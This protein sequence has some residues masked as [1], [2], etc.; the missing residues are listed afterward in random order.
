[1]GRTVVADDAIQT[2]VNSLFGN[3]QWYFGL[4]IGQVKYSVKCLMK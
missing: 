4:I 2:Y 1:M 3:G